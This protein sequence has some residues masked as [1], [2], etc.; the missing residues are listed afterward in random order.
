MERIL[1]NDEQPKQ[2][3]SGS[4]ERSCASAVVQ[5]TAGQRAVCQSALSTSERLERTIAIQQ[6]AL[7]TLFAISGLV[8]APLDFKQLVSK[9][10]ELVLPVVDAR[11]GIFWAL[12][13]DKIGRCRENL[14][15]TKTTCP[16]YNNVDHRCWSMLKTECFHR[17]TGRAASCEEKLVE[18]MECPVLSETALSAEACIGHEEEPYAEEMAVG[19]PLCKKLLLRRPSISVYHSFP[20]NGGV[21]AYEQTAWL[22]QDAHGDPHLVEDAGCIAAYSDMAP[23]TRIGLGL[24]TKNQIIGVICLDL[25][26]LHYLSES[27]VSLLTNICRENDD[28][29]CSGGGLPLHRFKTG[30]KYCHHPQRA[31]DDR[32]EARFQEQAFRKTPLQHQKGTWHVCADGIFG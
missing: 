2:Q 15:C 4:Q 1:Q 9:I 6:R 12:H 26:M 7:E 17:D 22:T 23:N 30:D 5:G 16:A 14:T 27:E 24:V 19:N 31:G 25:K 32:P 8:S 21:E 13:P 20:S 18:C 3:R 11:N 28:Q 10:L 29:F